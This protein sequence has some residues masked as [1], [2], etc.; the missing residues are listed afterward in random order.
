M[1]EMIGSGFDIIDVVWDW[2]SGNALFTG[3]FGVAV[4]LIVLGS[5]IGIFMKKGG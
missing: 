3:L 2:I 4:A 5:L 1:A